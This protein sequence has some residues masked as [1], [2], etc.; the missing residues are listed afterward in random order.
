MKAQEQDQL[1][2]VITARFITAIDYLVDS[3]RI[4][5]VVEFEKIT[6]IR[7]QRITGMKSSVAGE[8]KTPNYVGI[9]QIKLLKDHFNVSMQYIFDGIKPIVI[10]PEITQSSSEDV[11][12]E[13]K[14][15]NLEMKD[16]IELL[17]QK[18]EFLNEKIDFYKEQLNQKP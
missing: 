16:Q 1:K 4:D 2:S 3:G 10:D 13:Y 11:P 7:R 8:S 17:K 12:A 6:G 14:R 15:R 18:I 5:S 9:N